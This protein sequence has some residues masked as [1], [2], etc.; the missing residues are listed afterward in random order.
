ML[1]LHIRL[2]VRPGP[3]RYARPSAA[4]PQGGGARQAWTGQLRG[5]WQSRHLGPRSWADARL[6]GCRGGNLSA[7][8]GRM[9]RDRGH[10]EHGRGRRAH[11]S[12][13]GRRDD[14]CWWRPPLADRGRRVLNAHPAIVESAA[15]E[16]RVK[17][18]TT[19]IA[20]FYVS[21][22]SVET[23]DLERFIAGSPCPLQV[24]AHLR[25]RGGDSERSEQQ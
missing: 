14:E 16:V 8:P 21:N 4:G 9:V 6:L 5:A 12:R 19:V 15:T 10:D 22:A 7:L 25:A 3:E 17:A 2:A 20:A 13:Q 11:L 1:D 23:T 24:P 18:D